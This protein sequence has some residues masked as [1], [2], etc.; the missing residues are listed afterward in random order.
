[1]LTISPVNNIDYYADLAKEDYY[2]GSGEPPGIWRGLGARQLG[3]NDTIVQDADYHQLMKGYAPT[4]EALVQNAGETEKRRAAWDCCFSAPKSVSLA[5]AASDA[6]LRSNIKVAQERAVSKAID[7]MER[8]AATTRRGRSGKTYERTA[9]LV[10]ATFDHCTNREQQPQLHTHALVCN[11]APRMD[12]SWGSIDSRKIYQWQKASGA[13]YRAELAHQLRGLGFGLERDEESFRI[14][15]IEKSLCDRYSKRA[16]DINKLLNE[17]GI[18]SSASKTGDRLKL[19]TRK[20]KQPVEHNLLLEQWQ[21]EMAAH[22]L[23][24]EAVVNL[25]KIKEEEEYLNIEP[26]IVFDEIAEQNAVFTEREV[27]QRFALEA[28]S[29]GRTAEEAEKIARHALSSSSLIELEPAEPFSKLFTTE[30]VVETERLMISNARELANRAT[31]GLWNESILKAIAS[32]ERDLGFNF[33]DEQY[34]AIYSTLNGSDLCITQGSAGAGKTTMMLAA[35]YAYGGPGLKLRGACIAKK[36]ADNLAQETGIESQTIASLLKPM[37]DGKNPL[38]G[39]DVMVLDEGG[40]IPVTDMQLLLH[41][42]KEAECKIIITGEDK[43]LDAISRGG[44]LRYLSRPSV[45]GAQRIQNIRR[46]NEE[47]ARDTVANLRDGNAKFALNTLK[48]RNCLHWG[49]GREDTKNKLIEDWRYFHKTNP[50]KRSLVMAQKWTDVKELSEIIRSIYIEEGKVGEE[51]ISITCSVA[52]K[53]F[54]YEFSVG[55]RIKFCRN[56]YQQLKVSNGTLGTIRNIEQ[57]EDDVRLSVETDDER[58]VSFLASEYRDEK[59]TNICLAY[60][61]TVYSAQGT[62][63]RGNTFTLYSGGMDRANSYVGLSRHK[64]EAHLYVNQSEIDERAGAYDTG[65]AI[66]DSERMDTLSKLMCR[67]NYSSL[68]IEHLP[69]QQIAIEETVELEIMD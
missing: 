47:W 50:D 9:G 20:N 67:D 46:Q 36:A 11:A 51:N 25:R 45:I 23:T 24:N 53:K 4:G 39:I 69:E 16:Q 27:Y 15:G 8:N 44:A 52:D 17:S 22:G 19:L 30:E 55:D 41:A 35:K 64:D 56:E 42:A 43:Q 54:E 3:I 62:T 14:V 6:K 29:A 40:Q 48:E 1:M 2:L 32:A 61:L 5:W 68:A 21:D 7:F 34:E 28:V 31:K 57:L 58:E 37:E 12:G 59:G 26:D 10:V 60:A 66:T 33:D 65:K 38:K 63:V 13:I 49:S 18:K